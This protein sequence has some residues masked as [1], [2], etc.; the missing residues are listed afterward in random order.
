LLTRPY[1]FGVFFGIANALAGLIYGWLAVISGSVP[2]AVALGLSALVSI[3]T[4]V[5]LLRKRNFGLLLM[6]LMFLLVTIEAI[7]D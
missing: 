7:I 5:G 4:G 2:G 3:A 1:R 6:D